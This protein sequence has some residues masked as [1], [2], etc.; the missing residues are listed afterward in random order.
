MAS[1]LPRH[2][3]V[4]ERIAGTLLENPRPIAG[5]KRRNLAPGKA[6]ADTHDRVMAAHVGA[7]DE[8]QESRTAQR[9]RRAPGL[10]RDERSRALRDELEEARKA[11]C[12]EMMQEQVGDDHVNPRAGGIREP[13]EYVR[14]NRPERL[15]ID[16]M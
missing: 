13:F 14:G 11:R 5:P 15:A 4:T 12:F 1:C 9:Q 6:R 16:E 3:A 2:E 10:A 8:A 7:A